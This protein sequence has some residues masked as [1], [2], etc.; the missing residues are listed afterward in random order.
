MVDK[1]EIP[2]IGLDMGSFMVKGVLLEGDEMALSS[3]PVSGDPLNA[4]KEALKRLM[5]EEKE[6]EVYLGITGAN[7]HLLLP[8]WGLRPLLEI[9]ALQKGLS[10]LQWEGDSL[11][12][13]GHENMYYLELGEGR[14]V[15]FFNRNSQCAA[16]SGAF[17]YQQATRMGYNDRELA[18]IALKAHGEVRISGRCAV[19][20][21][22][23]MTHAINEG[24]TLSSVSA[25]MAQALAQMVLTSVAQNRIENRETLLVTGGVGYNEAVMQYIKNYC[26]ESQVQVEIPHQQEYLG[27][28]GAA[29]Q[30]E[31]T[32]LYLHHITHGEY[33][34]ENPLPPLQMERAHY[35]K[36][37]TLEEGLDLSTIY[38]G[39]DC[40]SVSTKGVLIDARGQS[41]GGIYLPTAGRPAL[42]VLE[43]MKELQKKYADRLEGAEIIAA[44]TGSGRFLSQKILGAQ[45]A[46]DEITCQGEGVKYYF[47]DDEILSIIEIGGEDS[48]FLKLQRGVLSDYN[49]NPVCAAGTGTFL[50]NLAGLLGV[51]IK[52]EFSKKAFT[53]PFAIDL[54]DTCTLLSQS[55]LVSA[56]SRGLSLSSQLASLAISSARNYLSRTVENRPLEGRLVFTGATAKNQALASAFAA[57]SRQEI[58]IPPYPELTGALGAALIAREFHLGGEKGEYTFQDLENFQSFTVEQVK[59]K[60]QCEHDHNCTLDCITFAD[61][62]RFLYGDRCNRYSGLDRMGSKTNLPDYGRRRQEA[63]FKAVQEE[64]RGEKRIQV[65]IA[66]GGLFYELYP[67]W[68]AFFQELDMEVV[69]SKESNEE[70]LEKGK[71]DLE[72]EMCYPLEV[73]VGHYQD[74]WEQDLDYIFLPEVVDMES[75][76]WAK[77]WPRG[78]TCPLLQ[79]IRGVVQSSLTIPDQRILYAQLNYRGGVGQVRSQLERMLEPISHLTK[80]RVKQAVEAGYK[81]MERYSSLLMEEGEQMIEEMRQ[82]PD[83]VVVLFLGRSYTLYDDF[84]SKGSLQYARERG[85]LAIPSDLLLAYLEGW[86]DGRIDSSFLPDSARDGFMEEIEKF[87]A[88]LDNVYPIQLQ[89]MV[90]AV[91]FAQYLNRRRETTHLP[92]IHFIIQDPFKCGPNAML[93]HLLWNM[94][95]YLRLTLDEHTAPAGMITRL[96]A[97]RNTC[98]SRIV[99]ESIRDY[100]PKVQY[101][102]NAQME[103]ILIPTP[104]HHSK[105]FAT[106]FKNYGIEALALPQST[107]QDLIL[108]RKFVNGDECLPMIQNVQ[109]FLEFLEGDPGDLN[110]SLFFQG[111][112]CGPCRY[113]LYAST[114]SLILD[115]AGYGPGRICAVRMEDIIKRYGVSALVETYNGLLAMDLLYKML[116]HT[117]PYEV[118]RGESDA[119]F[120]EYS[121]RLLRVLDEYRVNLLQLLSGKYLRPLQVFLREASK[122]FEDIERKKEKRP[123]IVLA[124]EFYVRLDNRCNQNII[125]KV[126]NAGGEVLLSPASEIFTYTTFINYREIAEALHH[127][128][129]IGLYLKKKGYGLINWLAHRDERCLEMAAGGLLYDQTEPSPEEI[130][131]LANKYVS[132]HY[133]GE[134]PMTIGR[135]AAFTGRRGVC[136]AIF[137][138]PFTCMPGSVV[139]SQMGVLRDDLEIPIITIY[140]DGKENAN[141]EEFIESL[142]FQAKQRIHREE[143]G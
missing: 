12:S 104:T 78:F 1:E 55:A 110:G 6:R 10:Y 107:D 53:A 59:C 95:P 60:A 72:A 141:R 8:I 41:M 19:F 7:S 65:G 131:R 132:P 49:M 111:W 76:P 52:E 16:G 93:R 138:A 81:A 119:L 44:T 39:V 5:G 32:L 70:I 126:E 105:V 40:G 87:L 98:S 68:S 3:H 14:E 62:S 61:K 85:L 84:I 29:L 42:Q 64:K 113:G 26:R 99:G 142:V 77:D 121:D 4:A 134:P 56:A 94:T 114:Q 47:R 21:K 31:K 66:R 50:E 75:L 102:R 74:L 115:R 117:R 48:K 15:T 69:L 89:R 143:G 100:S 34:P 128:K 112:A 22:S 67:F 73:L 24:A 97:F 58:Y 30:G 80:E 11:L 33:V 51:K 83:Q 25:G 71:R 2:F 96:E 90:S 36:P 122:A 23:D 18:E 57:E 123:G 139:E 20:A 109:D 9:K 45:Y 133:G 63:F 130:Q 127:Q 101:V 54:G 43:L 129:R 92:S 106:I 35:I 38:L 108:A 103:R 46:I 37:P 120:E 17:W 13:L 125:R 82:D 136:G 116:Y 135:T 137:V 140:Y 124:G 79:T 28:I 91:F 86:Y 118:H 88:G 27:A